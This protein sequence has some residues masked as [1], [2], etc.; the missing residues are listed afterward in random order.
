MAIKR[1]LPLFLLAGVGLTLTL[2]QTGTQAQTGA[3]Q[4]PK[5]GTLSATVVPQSVKPGSKAT[6]T[7]TVALAP[8]FHIYANKPDAENVIPTSLIVT[9]PAKESGVSFGAPVYPAA[10]SATVAGIPGKV[11]VYE[12]KVVFKIP[13]TVAKNAK[14]TT[15][16]NAAIRMQGCNDSMCYPPKNFKVA[17][18][19]TVAG[20]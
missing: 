10:I 18:N 5:F 20:G 8:G 9:P 14:G 19:L 12:G 4:Q 3:P 7:I 16:L 17:A 13:V 2:A 1:Y 15:P 6:L 11:N